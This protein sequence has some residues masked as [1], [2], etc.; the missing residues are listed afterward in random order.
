MLRF[1][2][3]GASLW[4]GALAVAP[5]RRRFRKN[6][7]GGT[8]VEFALVATPFLAILFAIIETA[9]AFWST[10]VLDTAV[11]DASRRL[12]TG[13]FQQSNATVAPSELPTKFRDELCKNIVAM[14]SCA[15]IKVDVRTYTSFPSAAA[16]PPVT[17]SGQFDSA[18]FGQFMSP[19]Q[20]DIVVVRA[21]VE[22]PILVSLLSPRQTN[23]ANG[24]RLIMGTAAFRAE[25]FGS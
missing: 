7:S 18:N 19:Q 15:S 23:L 22:I 14:F 4:R 12:Y 2:F 11:A 1:N 16:A 8:A 3:L 5:A 13:Q 24:N 21:A 10:T 9:I 25:P 20:N 6:E 17:P